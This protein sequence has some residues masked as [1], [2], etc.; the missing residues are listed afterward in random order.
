MTKNARTFINFGLTTLSWIGILCILAMILTSKSELLF[1]GL[2]IIGLESIIRIVLTR[3]YPEQEPSSMSQ[4]QIRAWESL[5]AKGKYS[6]ARDYLIRTVTPVL[7]G[8]LFYII[9]KI[10]R[11]YWVKNSVDN[12]S[13]Y[14]GVKNTFEY[15]GILVLL[16][17]IVFGSYS[18]GLKAWESHE[19]NYKRLSR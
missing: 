12:I 19:E 2:L 11:A 4:E 1:L 8:I 9:C 10:V 18:L 6:Y 16:I 3:H 17:I 7:G 14:I 15:V 13:E 5:R